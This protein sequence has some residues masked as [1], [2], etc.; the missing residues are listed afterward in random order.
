MKIVVL[1]ADSIGADV[2][3]GGLKQFGEVQLYS[4]TPQDKIAERIAD[5]DIVIPNK[6][7]LNEASLQ[8]ASQVKIICEAATG[9][10]NIDLA[11]CKSR[12]ITVTNVRGYSTDI[13]AQHTF[14][15]LLSLYE[16][17]DYYTTYVEDGDYS[18]GPAFSHVTRPFHELAG[19]CFGIIGMGNIGRKVAEIATAFGANVIYYSA[20]GHTYDVPYAVKSWS[21]F[22]KEADIISIHAPLNASTKG[23]V[24]REALEQMKRTAILLN[25]GRGPII[26][27]KD[28]AYALE[29]GWIAAAGL[30]V[31]ETEPLPK[32]SPLLQVRDRD[33][34]L[35]T[36]HMAW[37][38]T[39]ARNRLVKD[40][41]QSIQAFLQGRRRSVVEE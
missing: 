8:E 40:I 6:C 21:A 34:L 11:Y 9:Y 29:N 18:A 32:T 37:G 31:Y 22:L 10:N 15:M 19:K 5:A 30:D 24:N 28:L 16:K 20:S 4:A 7:V 25:L 36:P 38:S 26:V 3:W 17:L 41:E 23:L 14:A 1:E 27:E 35:M 13:V 33:R 2:S 12:G 39:E